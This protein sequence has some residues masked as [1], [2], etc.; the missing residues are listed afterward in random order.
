MLKIALASGATTYR[1]VAELVSDR[2][3]SFTFE[4]HS[5]KIG[6]YVNGKTTWGCSSL[7]M[8]DGRTWNELS[9]IKFNKLVIG[10]NSQPGDELIG[11]IQRLDLYKRALYMRDHVP[12]MRRLN[13]AQAVTET[14]LTTNFIY[15]TVNIE[16]NAMVGKLNPLAWPKGQMYTGNVD[17]FT[18]G[19][20]TFGSSYR[21]S[22]WSYN[23]KVG[24]TYEV[25]GPLPDTPTGVEVYVKS[26]EL[27]QV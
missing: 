14:M 12:R 18:T 8:P 3:H 22:D 27:K 23:K 11:G 13:S 1:K 2:I 24:I 16:Q 21:P 5:G 7:T 15:P 25:V 17:A 20:L 10:H 4:M 26:S 9:N 19:T 6:A